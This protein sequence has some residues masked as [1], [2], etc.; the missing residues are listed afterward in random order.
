MQTRSKGETDSFRKHT[1]KL[2]SLILSKVC[3]K[4]LLKASLRYAGISAPAVRRSRTPEGSNLETYR[5][6]CVRCNSNHAVQVHV[7]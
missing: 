5:V 7:V 1:F 4:G 6:L 2:R 3:T